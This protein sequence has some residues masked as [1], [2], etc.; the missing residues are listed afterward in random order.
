MFTPWL[1][2]DHPGKAR[3]GLFANINVATNLTSENRPL[4]QSFAKLKHYTVNIRTLDF[5]H[6]TFLCQIQQC[7][8][9]S[10]FQKRYFHGPWTTHNNTHNRTHTTKSTLT[11]N[12]SASLSK[13]DSR[14]DL[15]NT[16]QQSLLIGAVI[17]QPDLSER[18]VVCCRY[19]RMKGRLKAWT[20]CNNSRRYIGCCNKLELLSGI[21]QNFLHVTL[22]R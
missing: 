15:E 21:H 13:K 18:R 20:E 11:N 14:L 5:C 6:F 17:Q 8:S 3:Q 19:W 2:N 10:H 22:H 9:F 12:F 7:Q 4:F 1:F 16:L